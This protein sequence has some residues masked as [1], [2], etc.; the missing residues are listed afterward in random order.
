MRDT[1]WTS[2]LAWSAVL[3]GVIV[4]WAGVVYLLWVVTA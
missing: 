3:V 4:F 1:N 2:V